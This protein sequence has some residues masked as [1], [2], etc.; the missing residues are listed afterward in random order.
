MGYARGAGL[1]EK[2]G[3]NRAAMSAGYVRVLPDMRAFI[4]HMVARSSSNLA[5]VSIEC[6]LYSRELYGLAAL[7]A[8]VY[9]V[10]DLE[11]C[12]HVVLAEVD[13]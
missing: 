10:R 12:E 3:L 1:Y 7:S 6:R 11:L 4:S 13:E 2:A 8:Q 5:K 9:S